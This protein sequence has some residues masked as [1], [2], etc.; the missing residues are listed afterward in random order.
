MKASKDKTGEG[1]I[2]H[3]AAYEAQHK[4][5]HK[6]MTV[7]CTKPK[8][9]KGVHSRTYE[10]TFRGR[11][12][13]VTIPDRQEPDPTQV[14]LDAIKDCLTP[15]AVAAVVSCLRINRTNNK[16]V[17]GQVHWF[18]EELTKALGGHEE[19]SRLAE[20]LGL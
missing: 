19:Q 15:E 4:A 10:A 13:R 12:T 7:K 16:D 11:K 14:M 2:D 1:F 9:P 18:A 5:W 3:T 20:E 8:P 17:D 6:E